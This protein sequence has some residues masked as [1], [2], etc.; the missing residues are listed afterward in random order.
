MKKFT[1]LMGIIFAAF[2]LYGQT[3]PEEIEKLQ[4]ERDAIKV[5]A[6]QPSMDRAPAGH[7]TLQPGY[8]QPVFR[9]DAPGYAWN[10]W[11]GGSGIPEGPV[12]IN[13][14]DGSLLSI[15]EVS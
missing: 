11:E 7:H 8:V 10:V 9:G 6:V 15:Q 14:A 13:L 1:M 4:A 5:E 12:H 3:S 2:T